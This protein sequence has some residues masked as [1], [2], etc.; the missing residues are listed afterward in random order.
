M[1][2]DRSIFP[3]TDRSIAWLANLIEATEV[4]ATSGKRCDPAIVRAFS[5]RLELRTRPPLKP[6]HVMQQ[7]SN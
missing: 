6:I 4:V 5:H 7:N 3:S 2:M 1:G